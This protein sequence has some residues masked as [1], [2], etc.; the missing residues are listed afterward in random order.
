MRIFC[1]SGASLSQS[2]L[3]MTVAPIAWES[4]IEVMYLTFVYHC[5]ATI[6]SAEP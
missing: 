4:C 5:S 6:E 2:R 3:M 1:S